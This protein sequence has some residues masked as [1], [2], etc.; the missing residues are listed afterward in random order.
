MV[1]V[2]GDEDVAAVVERDVVRRAE[3]PL[4]RP[5][6]SP[7]RH[8]DASLVINRDLVEVRMRRHDLG[9]RIDREAR[10][11]D[12]PLREERALRVELLDAVV[13]GVACV[14]LPA[15]AER[16]RVRAVG[17]AQR[18]RAGAA[19]L[20]DEL[21]RRV[22][23]NREDEKEQDEGAHGLQS[24]RCWVM[25]P[26]TNAAWTAGFCIADDSL[27]PR[28]DSATF[29]PMPAPLRLLA[30]LAHPDDETLGL[31][32]TLARYASEG[33]ET[34]LVTATRGQAG[35]FKELKKGEPGHPGPDALGAIRSR[36]S[37]P[38]PACWACARSCCSTTWMLAGPR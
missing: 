20:E 11:E 24:R 15:G 30:I 10:A 23:R 19:P 17:L 7:A 28:A 1:R 5:G 16:D 14:T 26:T 27:K 2:V 18:P 38:P 34:F 12:R 29:W 8:L 4:A 22:C 9:Q 37:K 36:S 21:R 33:V 35:R 6:R 25:A 3:L 32:G 31:G 13:A